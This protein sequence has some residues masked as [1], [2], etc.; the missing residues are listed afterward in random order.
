MNY[1]DVCGRFVKRAG[2]ANLFK[3]FKPDTYTRAARILRTNPAGKLV[4]KVLLNN[5]KRLRNTAIGAGILG[6]AGTGGAY[7]AGRNA[8]F[9]QGY[10]TERE[11]PDWL[12][13]ATLGT[14]G[15]A[16]LLAWGISSAADKKKRRKKRQQT[17]GTPEYMEAQDE[18]QQQM[19]A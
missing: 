6:L 1:N 8:G 16:G 5:F 18:Q 11:V 14:L 2:F 17:P 15:A 7:V 13:Y 9:D 10:K 4:D 12:P 19:M 3:A